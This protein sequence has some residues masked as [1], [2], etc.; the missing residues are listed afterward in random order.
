MTLV[1]SPEMESGT[2]TVY[3]RDASGNALWVIGLLASLPSATAGYAYGCQYTCT[4]TGAT[5]INQG[6]AT[7]CNFIALV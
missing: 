3:M 4:D 5:Y 2:V 7:S 6:G 1:G